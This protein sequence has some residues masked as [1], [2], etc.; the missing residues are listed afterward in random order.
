MLAP[1]PSNDPYRHAL[2]LILRLTSF[3][4]AAMAGAAICAFG[5]SRFLEAFLPR[6]IVVLVVIFERSFS[7]YVVS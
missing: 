6:T 3:H 1:D 4:R 2:P 5:V 7:S